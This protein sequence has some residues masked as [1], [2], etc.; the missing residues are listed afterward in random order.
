MARKFE[1]EPNSICDLFDKVTFTEDIYKTPAQRNIFYDARKE[2]Y[3]D[4]APKKYKESAYFSCKKTLLFA[5]IMEENNESARHDKDNKT[6]DMT[7]KQFQ[8]NDT[9]KIL[10]PFVK[11]RYK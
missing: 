11:A 6:N 10:F 7:L 8:E 9:V 3:L 2:V 1:E 4:I 5:N